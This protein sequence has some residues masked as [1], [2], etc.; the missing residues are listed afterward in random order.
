MGSHHLMLN[1]SPAFG[2]KHSFGVRSHKEE[3]LV[4]P[5]HF[6]VGRLKSYDTL[7]NYRSRLVDQYSSFF[8]KLAA[9]GL[10]ISFTKVKSATGSCPEALPREWPFLV[11]KLESENE[12]CWVRTSNRDDGRSRM[13]TLP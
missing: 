2:R 4:G 10:R 7:I 8:V 13:T 5:H 6:A 3:T 11:L 9:C 12:A 1:L